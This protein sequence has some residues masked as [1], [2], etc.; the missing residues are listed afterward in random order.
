MSD[1]L[2]RIQDAISDARGNDWVVAIGVAILVQIVLLFVFRIL[3]M[4][5]RTATFMLATVVA[6]VVA[7]IVLD[8]HGL[9][10][11]LGGDQLNRWI[12]DLRGRLDV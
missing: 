10:D 1:L 9:P 4:F 6:I 8:H 7:V 12:D 5:L 2:D 11:Y 3:G